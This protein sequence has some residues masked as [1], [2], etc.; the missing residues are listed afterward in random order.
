MTDTFTSTTGAA[1]TTPDPFSFQDV[2]DVDLDTVQISNMITVTGIDA[3]APVSI[4]GGE[5]SVNGGPYTSA[6]GIVNANDADHGASYERLDRGHR[7][8]LHAD[9]RRCV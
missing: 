1:D 5:Y 4:T 7:D 9:D 6:D 2:S 3:A 8:R